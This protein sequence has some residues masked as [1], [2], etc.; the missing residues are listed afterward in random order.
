VPAYYVALRQAGPGGQPGLRPAY[1]VLRATATGATLA[2]ITPPRPFGTFTA[3]TAAANDRTFVLAAAEFPKAAAERLFVLHV[4]PASRTLAGRARLAPLPFAFIQPG[5]QAWDLA[6]SP[7]SS[8]LALAAGSGGH[9]ELQ[10]LNLVTGTRR[11]WITVAGC[12]LC[13]STPWLAARSDTALSW[14]ADGRTLAVAGPDSMR[15]L[16]TAAPGGSLLADSRAAPE[17]PAM[18]RPGWRDALLV[19]DGQSIMAV[20]PAQP[21]RRASAARQ[22]VEVPPAT[23]QPVVVLGRLPRRGQEQVLWASGSGRALIV[24][25]T[26]PAAAAGIVLSGRYTPIPWSRAILAAAW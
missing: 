21:G 26:D 5:L 1:A 16:N 20:T 13:A 14:A 23:G 7:D 19:P 22:L 12:P 2:T 25:S 15:L 11:L 6:L 17:S 4:N 18:F 10:V 9:V 8:E 24:S 3:V